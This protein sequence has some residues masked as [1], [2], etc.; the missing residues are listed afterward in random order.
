ML[1]LVT[2]QLSDGQFVG[3][4]AQ[5]LRSFYTFVASD[6]T[7]YYWVLS[8]TNVLADKGSAYVIS[9]GVSAYFYFPA[10]LETTV[11]NPADGDTWYSNVANVLT[12]SYSGSTY[13]EKAKIDLYRRRTSGDE[14]VRTVTIIPY[15]FD[16][17]YTVDANELASYVSDSD[18]YCF[19]MY[20]ADSTPSKLF[21]TSNYFYL[22]AS[23]FTYPTDT[24]SVAPGDAVT[25]RWTASATISS[26]EAKL[27]LYRYR[28][29]LSD[30]KI[31]SEVSVSTLGLQSLSF[32]IP[33][34]ATASI[35]P[36]YFRLSY[37][38]LPLIG[39]W[40]STFSS[41][42][43]TVAYITN[44][45][46]DYSG[47]TNKISCDTLKQDSTCPLASSVTSPSLKQQ[48]CPFC[49]D[50]TKFNFELSLT[51]VTCSY[52]YKYSITRFRMYTSWLSLISFSMAFE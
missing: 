15:I 11:S 23:L 33:S 34:S 2:A 48:L 10:T 29:L 26:S 50:T 38:C 16:G 17:K 21:G 49:T 27:Q 42:Q 41:P 30:E 4:T 47:N 40:C 36:Y 52:S 25:I 31:G 35:L 19:R 14:F 8:N 12:W 51:C 1:I 24:T 7:K 6:D 20:D 5:S 18:M 32:T 28:P 22:P 45:L 37:N 39:A 3:L 9:G 46:K 43:F 44:S 13:D